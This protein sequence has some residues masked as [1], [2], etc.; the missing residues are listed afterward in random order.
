MLEWH[1]LLFNYLKFSLYGCG[2]MLK[3]VKSLMTGLY[4]GLLWEFTT[5]I[6]FIS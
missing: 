4:E 1:E 2:Y 5:E 6:Q 3:E